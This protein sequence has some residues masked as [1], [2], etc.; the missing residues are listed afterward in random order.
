MCSVRLT[1]QLVCRTDGQ[2]RLVA[3]YLPRH[4]A[5]TRAEQGCISFHVT[6]T[7]DVR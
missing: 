6:Q 4:I 7:A 2:A 3:D 5:L 1:G